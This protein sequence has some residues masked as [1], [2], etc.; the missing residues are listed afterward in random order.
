[1]KFET[2]KR[3]FSKMLEAV[4]SA[5]SREEIDF[6]LIQMNLLQKLVKEQGDELIT[7]VS[8]KSEYSIET[9]K[10]FASSSISPPCDKCSH[11]RISHNKKGCRFCDCEVK[12]SPGQL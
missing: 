12:R 7:I 3:M 11:K 2:E 5:K 9:P 8:T 10:D 6:N 4:L 1:M